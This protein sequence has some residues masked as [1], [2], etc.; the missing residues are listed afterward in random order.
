VTDI[1]VASSAF[2]SDLISSTKFQYIKAP[3]EAPTKH[4]IEADKRS[5]VQK[6]ENE[7]FGTYAGGGAK[8]EDITYRV[9]KPGAWGGYEIVKT[10]CH[11]CTLG[12]FSTFLHALFVKQKADQGYSREQLLDMRCSKK[13]DRICSNPQGS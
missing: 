9:R 7:A 8:G 3:K 6:R 1:F 10:V 2:S 13:A 5:K 12:W 11:L 4:Q